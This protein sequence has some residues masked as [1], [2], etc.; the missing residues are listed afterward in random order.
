MKKLLTLLVICLLLNNGLLSAQKILLKI[1]SITPPAGEEVKAVEFKI[2]AT[3]T[4]VGGGG[5][6][7]SRAIFHDLLIKKTNNTSTNELFKKLVTGTYIPVVVLEY[8]SASNVLYFT[9]TLKTV[10]VTNFFWLSPECPTCLK[11]DHQVAFAPKQIETTDAVTGITFR[12]DV[13]LNST[14]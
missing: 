8:Y 3:A 6:T 12:F 9:I 2:D 14:Y 11:L 7:S 5:G 13:S 4:W 1:A 10:I